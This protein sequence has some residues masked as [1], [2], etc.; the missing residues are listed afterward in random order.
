MF[1]ICLGRDVEYRKLCVSSAMEL[2]KGRLLYFFPGF[3][4]P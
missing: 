1:L 2:V 4:R 3:V